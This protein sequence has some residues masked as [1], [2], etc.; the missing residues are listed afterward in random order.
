MRSVSDFM[1]LPYTIT[2]V[3][4]P[5][6]WEL[7]QAARAIAQGGR[8]VD[9]GLQSMMGEARRRADEMLAGLTDTLVNQPRTELAETI[10]SLFQL[11]NESGR[12]TQ[13][14]LA[15]IRRALEKLKLFTFV[16]D[17]ETRAHM[18]SLQRQLDEMDPRLL[19]QDSTAL[20]SLETARTVFAAP[21]PV[22]RRRVGGVAG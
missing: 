2:L 21:A 1:D 19:S 14:S 7:P 11:V 9:R 16:E 13:K 22:R 4:V 12:V 5:G 17:P 10:S 20:A 6:A 8:G 15:P 18:D 3:R